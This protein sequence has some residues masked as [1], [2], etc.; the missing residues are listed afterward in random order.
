[1]PEADRGPNTTNLKP[2]P[3]RKNGPRVERGFG[4]TTTITVKRRKANDEQLLVLDRALKEADRLG[5][6]RRVMIA[7]VMTMTQE[8]SCTRSATNVD[9]GVAHVGPYQQNPA[10]GTE[11]ER[12]DP[13][14]STRRF[15]LDNNDGWKFHHGSVRNA[16]GDLAA[17]IERI[18]RSGNPLGPKQWQPEAE[19]TVDAFLGGGTP[20]GIE[21]VDAGGPDL[22]PVPYLFRRGSK[23]EPHSSWE[24]SGS[25]AKD[26]HGNRW[27]A[28]NTFFYVSDRELRAGKPSVEIHGD[29]P[30]LLEAP[31]FTWSARRTTAE[32]TLRLLVGT[33]E[34]QVGAVVI[35]AG[36]DALDGRYIV[37]RVSGDL[38]TPERTLTLRRPRMPLPEPATELREREQAE[39]TAP[40]RT[41]E[42]DRGVPAPTGGLA[43]LAPSGGWGGT[44]G[45]IRELAKI[46]LNMGKGMR[47][48]SAKRNNTNP[49]SGSRSDHDFANKNQYANDISNG[50][51]PTPEMDRAAYRM[52]QRLGFKNY[53]MGQPVNTSQGVVTIGKLRFQLIYRGSGPAF[54]GNHL[55]HIHIGCKRVL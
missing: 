12:R 43:D 51:T 26:V 49:Y 16:P 39:D 24:A 48:T 46:A 3:S 45:P 7:C 13:T 29:E 31:T 55:N 34:L 4:T 37:T 41:T 42:D 28:E 54:G 27:A 9:R 15:L 1:M 18:Q 21:G 53:K 25:W 38:R 32:V 47:V 35:L 17:A 36:Q 11:R 14:I 44:E 52:M 23:D 40:G 8:S 19:R 5:A 10:W 30:W 50:P 22:Y 6:S 20:L 33:V 2:K